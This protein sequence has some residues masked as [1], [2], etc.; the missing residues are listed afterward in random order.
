C[1]LPIYRAIDEEGVTIVSLVAVM[2]SRMLDE[3]G[4]APYPAHLR[5][6]L[7]GGGPAPLPLLERDLAAGVP[8]LQTYGLTETA[9]QVA[10]LAPGDALRKPGSA[11]K[12]L[13]PTRVRILGDGQEVPSGE[14]GEITVSWPTVT[15]GYWNRPD[16][17][18][19]ALDGGWL[20]TG[21]MGYLDA[22][23][24]LY[25]VDRREDLIISGGV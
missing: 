25:V 20:R 24:H 3:R 22:E 7:L 15:P 21:D 12:P 11:G 19:A 13:F 5:A 6:V 23:G 18:A 10:T 17:T 8:V 16:A 9:S 2:L 1:A 4:G 14:V